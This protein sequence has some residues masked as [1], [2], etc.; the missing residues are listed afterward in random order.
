VLA[1][2]HHPT[3]VAVDPDGDNLVA[4][5]GSHRVSIFVT[6]GKA[7][8]NLIGDAQALSKWG[9]QTVDAN[10]DYG[11]GAAPGKKLRTAV[12]GSP[13]RTCSVLLAGRPAQ[14]SVPCRAHPERRLQSPPGVDPRLR[15]GAPAISVFALGSRLPMSTA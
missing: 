3:D 14:P 5:W 9:R 2:S 11:K 4:D 6:E 1:P 10:P 7:I 13:R 12:G 8:C 15:I